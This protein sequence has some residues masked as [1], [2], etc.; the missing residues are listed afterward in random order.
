MTRTSFIDMRSVCPRSDMRT[1][2]SLSATEIAP[3]TRPLRARCDDG[4][5]ADAAAIRLTEIFDIGPFSIAVFTD[6]EKVLVGGDDFASDDGILG[7]A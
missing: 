1:T 2:L 6:D 7:I 4:A 3:T 5:Y